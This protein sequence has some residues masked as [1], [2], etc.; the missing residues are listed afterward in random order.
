MLCFTFITLFSLHFFHSE[1]VFARV[2]SSTRRRAELDCLNA[3][4]YAAL[5]AAVTAVGSGW[6]H[7]NAAEPPFIDDIY[8]YFYF[9]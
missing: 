5:S 1:Q 3:A 7:I 2:L 8:F 9:I 6:S 4:M